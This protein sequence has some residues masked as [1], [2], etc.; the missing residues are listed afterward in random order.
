M[1]V[2]LAALDN[3]KVLFGSLAFASG[4]AAFLS[5]CAYFGAVT[6]DCDDIKKGAS[7]VWKFSVKVLI[8]SSL[9]YCVPSVDDVW[10]VRVGLLKFQLASP[11]NI[12]K[13]TKVIER[14]AGELECKY[15][16]HCK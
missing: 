8:V 9:L 10:K 5:S 15:L 2:L 6:E 12:E 14:I 7:T 16:G 1:E 11:E 13:G 4:L 3:T